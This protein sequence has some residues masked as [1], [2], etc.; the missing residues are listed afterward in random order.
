MLSSVPWVSEAKV[1]SRQPF[2]LQ[3]RKVQTLQ[4]KFYPTRTALRHNINHPEV[5]ATDNDIV[6]E[7]HGKHGC[8][9]SL[10]ISQWNF[11]LQ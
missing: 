3:S 6:R 9:P 5:D 2:Y 4:K 11:G 8:K 10:D 7:R 1:I